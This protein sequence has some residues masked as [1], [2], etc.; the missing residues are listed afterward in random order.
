[1]SKELLPLL[2]IEGLFPILNKISIFGGLNDKQLYFLFKI[3]KQS[4]YKKGEYIFKQGELPSHIYIIQKGRVRFI[5]EVDMTP[6]QIFEFGEG[7]CIGEA[8][9]LSLQ[10][11]AVS[12]V[13]CEDTIIIA[14]S[15]EDFFKI[16]KKDKNLF[17]TLI[18][19]ITRE[20]C[21]RLKSS[22][23]VLLHYIDKSRCH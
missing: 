23:N 5:E 22:D 8:S 12:A 14:L 3:L 7:N 17:S 18:L 6:Y 2:D 9:V 10:P 13:A 1:M 19:N 11:H 16:F 21:R 4:N 20:I 15:K